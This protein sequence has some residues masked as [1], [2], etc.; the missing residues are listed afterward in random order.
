MGNREFSAALNS[1]RKSIEEMN[2]P[3]AD[4]FMEEFMES[5]SL[6]LDEQK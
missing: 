2:L 5:F 1:T 4:I 3:E 6:T